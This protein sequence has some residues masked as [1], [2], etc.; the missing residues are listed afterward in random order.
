[1]VK[2]SKIKS[3]EIVNTQ[4]K[5]IACVREIDPVTSGRF[6]VRAINLSVSASITILNAFDAPAASVPP[7]SVAATKP[8]LGNP[9]SAKTIAGRVVIIKSSTT[10]NFIR[11]IYARTNFICIAY[12]FALVLL[13]ACIRPKSQ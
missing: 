6:E 8:K 1:M 12:L 2:I 11:S 4:A 9:F 10:R 13:P 3:E 7:I 5:M